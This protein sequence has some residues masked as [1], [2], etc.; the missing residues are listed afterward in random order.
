MKK[1]VSITKRLISLMCVILV[2]LMAATA[3]F[4]RNASAEETKKAKYFTIE[5]E[6]VNDLEGER[7]NSVDVVIEGSDGS[8]TTI[9]LTKAEGWKKTVTLPAYDSANKEINYT[10]YE[11]PTGLDKYQLS[12]GADNKLAIKAIIIEDNSD[13]VPVLTYHVVNDGFIAVP[14]GN[15][16]IDTDLMMEDATKNIT[17]D[18]SYSKDAYTKY[19]NPFSDKDGT[20]T[21]PRVVYTGDLK[22]GLNTTNG[23]IELTWKEKAHDTLTGKKYDVKVTV[24]NIKIWSEV[25]ATDKAIAVMSNANDMLEMESFVTDFG[26]PIE[27]VVGVEADIRIEVVGAE[28][29]VQVYITDLDVGDYAMCYYDHTADWEANHGYD[30]EGQMVNYFGVDKS[31]TESVRLMSGVSSDIHVDPNTVLIYSSDSSKFA[32][33]EASTLVND[34]TT[35]LEF[36]ATA[37]SYSYTWTGSKCE[38]AIIDAS[39]STTPAPSEYAN[40]LT[41]TSSIY[42]IKYFYQDDE[43]KYDETKPEPATELMM[44]KPGTE[45]SNELCSD[46]EPKKEGYVLDTAKTDVEGKQT[47]SAS[48]TV[49]D[50]LVLK[51]YFKKQYRVIY[52]DN[53]E[54]K[55][56][57]PATQTNPNLDYGT[58][59]PGFKGEPYRQ[60]YIFEGWSEEPESEIKAVPATVTKN[61][62]YW[63]HWTPGPNKYK[64]EYYYEIG[65]KYPSTPQFTSDDRAAKTEDIVSVTEDDKIPKKAYYVLSSDMTAEWTGEV[66]PD[67]SLVLKV[68]FRAVAKPATAAFI[69]PVTGV[70]KG[71]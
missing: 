22:R 41:N 46:L 71:K 3:A 35:S 47:A 20:N 34:P 66:L 53:V 64:V 21:V 10:A 32:V 61:A 11:D 17:G 60:G 26:N 12:N 57:D 13:R 15:V 54:D 39:P 18:F 25:D 65:G 31:Y 24:T 50:P 2:A 51:V 28:G 9:S 63:A 70:E 48:H 1:N 33:K 69:A 58:K 52:H 42:Q 59:T 49:D 40:K 5:K 56:W 29:F 62:D 55:V 68:Y 38:T 36:L 45:L 43:G 19:A 30:L 6:W 8:T 67:G 7:P 23:M 27:N 4:P 14:D 44:V 37:A 16:T